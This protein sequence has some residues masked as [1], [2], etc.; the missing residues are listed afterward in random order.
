MD[1]SQDIE[2]LAEAEIR[3]SYFLAEQIK[4]TTTYFGYPE[5]PEN[6]DLSILGISS[7]AKL[8]LNNAGDPWIHGNAKMHTKEFEREALDFVARL[9]GIEDRYWGYIT[10]GGTEGNLYGMYMGREYFTA[11]NQ[12]PIFLYTDSSHYSLAKN[13]HLLGLNSKTINAQSSG[14]MDY[15][16]LSLVFDEL[17]KSGSNYGL[18]INLNIGTTMTGAIDNLKKVNACIEASKISRKNILIHADAA[19]L[20]F[21]YPFMENREI[22]FENGVTSIAI[23]G[24]KFPGAIHPCGIVLTDKV[25]HKT[26]FGD[27]WIPYVGTHDT[28]ISG[29]RNGFLALNLWYI[30]QKKGYDGFKEEGETCIENAKYLKNQL[31]EL[32]YPQVSHFPNQII[33]TFKKP[34][35]KLVKKYQLATQG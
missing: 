6:N 34:N 2:R 32:D 7:L 15:E 19:L 11:K 14:E 30:F 5:V 27:Q 8:H 18:V 23:S 1:K 35:I 28:T 31:T 24:H 4:N 17:Q 16:H 21:I 33:V 13:A 22:L 26:A 12:N 20:G 29:S 10:S 25:V 9:Y 3:L